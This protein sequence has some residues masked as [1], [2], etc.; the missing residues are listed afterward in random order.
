MLYV[1]NVLLSV[2]Q[3]KEAMRIS[4]FSL[5]LLSVRS[6][7]WLINKSEKH[8]REHKN[9]VANLEENYFHKHLCSIYGRRGFYLI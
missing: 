3:L 9:D 7:D 5:S 4:L 1:P 6:P 2:Q 8:E